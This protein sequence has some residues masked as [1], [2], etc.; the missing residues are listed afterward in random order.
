M[1]EAE[2]GPAGPDWE[3]RQATID[4]L[5][6]VLELRLAMLEELA[7][8]DELAAFADA[9]A[10]RQSIVAANEA[11]TRAH[12]N[13]DMEVWVADAGGE[14]VA[15]AGI[16]WF[17][18]PPAY[19]NPTGREAYILNVYTKPAWRRRGIARALM[20]K[21]IDLAG[22][23]GTGRTWLRASPYGRP[24]YESLGFGPHNYMQLH[25]EPPK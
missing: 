15:S 11:Y 13:R 19:R 18:F 1:S 6:A 3:L 23:S 22:E 17:D 10:D 25:S 9:G 8:P 4:D 24:L 2:R 14:L 12:L 5:A 20:E 7:T 16:I 21:L